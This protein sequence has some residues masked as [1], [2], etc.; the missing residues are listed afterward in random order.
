M[1]RFPVLLKALLA[2]G[3]GWTV[4]IFWSVDRSNEGAESQD[5]KVVKLSLRGVD[6]RVGPE[7]GG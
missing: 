3:L 5:E 4:G 7:I 2:L 6:A 1:K